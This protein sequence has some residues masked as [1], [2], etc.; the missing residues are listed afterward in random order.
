MVHKQRGYMKSITPHQKHFN[1]YSNM[2]IVLQI[3]FNSSELVQYFCM[4]IF[5]CDN[6]IVCYK[7]VLIEKKNSEIFLTLFYNSLL[8]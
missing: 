4:V 3:N 2:F 6:W 7:N 8:N 5:Y 1:K